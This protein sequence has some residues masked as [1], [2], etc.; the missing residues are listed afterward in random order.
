MANPTRRAQRRAAA[1]QNPYNTV[2]LPINEANTARYLTL[3]KLIN[4]GQRISPD[5]MYFVLKYDLGVVDNNKLATLTQKY[6]ASI[7]DPKQ[8][9]TAEDTTAL[10]EEMK[11]SL[12]SPAYKQQILTALQKAETEDYTGKLK[13]AMEIA[14]GATNMAVG[15]KQLSAYNKLAKESTKPAAP[16]MPVETPDYQAAR[17]AVQQSIYQPSIAQKAAEAGI[18]E[19]YQAELQ[20]AKTAAGGQAGAYGALAQSAA[21]RRGRRQVELAPQIAQ[22]EAEN[23]RNLI[24]FGADS[25]R[26]QQ[27]QYGNA[28]NMYQQQMQNYADQQKTLGGLRSAGEQN[29]LAAGTQMLQQVPS[30]A[31]DR[32]I[33]QKYDTLRNQLLGMSVDPNKIDSFTNVYNNLGQRVGE[34]ANQA[35]IG[36]IPNVNNIKYNINPLPENLPY[37]SY[38][39]ENTNPGISNPAGLYTQPIDDIFR[40]TARYKSIQGYP[41]SY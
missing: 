25:Q 34:A 35:A 6:N 29:V 27:Q 15:A 20:N 12:A 19:T 4:Q 33:Q 14:I 2:M 36:S 38:N 32:R 37:P 21:T 11:K 8:R 7:T 1:L 30:I 16:G 5:D 18:K 10:L 26:L 39:L 41:V 28:V 24:N 17:R 13:S 31:G 23:R 22:I 40:N 3:A 9:L